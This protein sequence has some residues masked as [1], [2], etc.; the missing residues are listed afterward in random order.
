MILPLKDSIPSVHRPYMTWGII[1]LTA[2]VFLWQRTLPPRGMIAALHAFGLV[3]A[4]SSLPTFLTYALLH[5]GWWHAISNLWMFWIFADNIEDVMGPWRFLLFYASCAVVSGIVHVAANP[6]STTP[7]VG[8]SGAISGVLGAYFLLYP[9]AKITTLV[10]I[11]I[12]RLPAALYLGGWFLLQLVSGLG[13]GSSEVAWWAHLGGFVTGML[14][15]PLFRAKRPVPRILP[16]PSFAPPR[17]DPK[18]PW[19][20]YRSK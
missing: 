2:A 6:G 5:G 14:L 17:D 11:L 4:D 1:A 19:A 15:L 18:D 20:R 10:F 12:L 13:G 16:E 9:H 3:P 7:V 8:A